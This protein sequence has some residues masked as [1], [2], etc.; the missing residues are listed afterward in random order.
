MGKIQKIINSLIIKF[1]SSLIDKS[2]EFSD[3][4]QKLRLKR[5]KAAL[6]TRK[7]KAEIRKLK[8]QYS[9]FHERI[10][11][12]ATHKAVMYFIFINCTVVEIFSMRAMIMLADL[13]ALPTL[14][15]AVITESMSYAV[16]CAKSYSGTKQEKIQELDEKK[17]ELEREIALASLDNNNIDN[18][19]N[20]EDSVG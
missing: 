16:Y 20:N 10:N 14:M 13:S 6:E 12:F 3:N 18:N 7:V 11:K 19:L 17:F 4:I 8:V 1:I 5:A 9:P 2:S 15:V